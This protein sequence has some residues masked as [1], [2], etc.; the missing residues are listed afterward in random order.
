MIKIITNNWP[1]KLICLIIALSF[2]TYVASSQAKVDDFPG[3]VSL[4]LTNTPEGLIPITD[5]EKIDLKIVAERS[6][7]TKLSSE[8]IRASVNLTNL[9][10]GTHEL[11]I[12]I[13][14]QI[15]GV[16]I[17]D[18]S[19]QKALIRLEPLSKKNIPINVKIEGS[20]AEEM[21]PG[22]AETQPEEVEISG[23]KSIV[24]RILE[25]SA[26]IRLDGES[27][28][29]LKNVHLVALNADSEKINGIIFTPAEVKVTIP[30]IKAG[31]TKTVG[32]KLKTTGQVASGYWIS[33]T[34]STP[35]AITIT[36]KS[37]ELR[38]VNYLET[39]ALNIDGLNSTTSKTVDLDIPSGLSIVDQ[40]GSVQ[41]NVEISA[42]STNKLVVAQ[43]S[44]N[45]LNSSL[46]ISSL[47]PSSISVNLAGNTNDLIKATSDTVK[48]NLDLS[49][50]SKEGIYSIDITNNM[51]STPENISIISFLPSSLTLN[52]VKK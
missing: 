10:Q 14:S 7:W 8:Y 27:E 37:S 28:D 47:D 39:K 11:P 29:V 52:L 17:V 13:E 15:S 22:V 20:A 25:A 42:T 32:I 19:P 18:Y 33:N 40:I 46:K 2:W 3:G 48:L 36:G 30:I 9:E 23:A 31:T 16:E 49:Q 43:I 38:S 35:A 4:E 1:V 21:M 50:Y 26:V 12:K 51:V 41:V 45:N 24:D 5:V 6:I 34:S 44:P